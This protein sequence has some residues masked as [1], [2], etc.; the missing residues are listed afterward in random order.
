MAVLPSPISAVSK[1]LQAVLEKALGT[2]VTVDLTPPT[3]KDPQSL[4]GPFVSVWLYQVTA[5]EFARNR[6]PPQVETV[7]GRK[8]RLRLPPLGVNLWY[9][10]TPVFDNQEDAQNVLAAVL[11]GLHEEAQVVVDDPASEAG[12]VLGVS[13]VP[14][15]LDD[16]VKLWEALGQPYR[17]SACYQVRTVRL[18]SKQVDGAT[19]V[20]SLTARSEEHPGP[21]VGD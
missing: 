10:V 13:L 14:D 8:V 11:L 19:P 2:G 7:N 6:T 21:R 18:V 17:L 4:G 16:R 1:R 15:A 3:R 9:L 20:G 12:A 5:D